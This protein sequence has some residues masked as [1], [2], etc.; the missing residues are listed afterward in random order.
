MALSVFR[1]ILPTLLCN[2]SISREDV[3]MLLRPDVSP[4]V[5]EAPICMAG[6]CDLA[7]LGS[8]LHWR[9]TS[10]NIN[11]VIVNVGNVATTEG[12]LQPFSGV[13]RHLCQCHS[14][15]L[16]PSLLLVRGG[17]AD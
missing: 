10:P 7:T 1:K 6:R 2:S 11:D 14:F 9:Q 8:K 16:Q 4:S 12:C 13:R 15:L 3:Q 17:R 5:E